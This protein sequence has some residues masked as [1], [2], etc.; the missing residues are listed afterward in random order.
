[1][2]DR[3]A[4]IFESERDLDEESVRKARRTVAHHS[5]DADDCRMLLAA[6]GIAFAHDSGTATLS[7]TETRSGTADAGSV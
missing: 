2:S 3:D 1:M 5:I 7:D 4:S 6:L